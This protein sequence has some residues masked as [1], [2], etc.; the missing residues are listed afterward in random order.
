MI[1]TWG[2][3]FIFYQET[4]KRPK[5]GKMQNRETRSIQEANSRQETNKKQ[6]KAKRQ[7]KGKQRLSESVWIVSILT[8][9]LLQTTKRQSINCL[10]NALFSPTF[11]PR[12]IYNRFVKT[13]RTEY[14]CTSPFTTGAGGGGAR[15][16]PLFK[17]HFSHFMKTRFFW[18]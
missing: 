10:S 5:A 7:T 11:S 17:V 3:F 2:K 9:L 6:T 15:K 13:A 14:V 16:S 18:F 1:R 8:E 4:T 12:N